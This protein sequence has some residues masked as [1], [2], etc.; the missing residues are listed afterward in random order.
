MARRLR[1][2]MVVLAACL[3]YALA[4]LAANGFD[5]RALV[6]IG[7]CYA[8]CAGVETCPAEVSAGYDGQFAYYIARDPLNAAPCLDVPAYRYQ[9]ILLP[10]LGRLLALGQEGALPLAFAAINLAAL[11]ISTAL[12]ERLLLERRVSRWYALVYGLF[13]GL[14]M[15]VR[16]ST[17]EPLAYGLAALALWLRL[18]GRAWPGLLALLLAAFAKETALTFAAAFILHDLLAR[19]WGAA[20][21]TA[22]VI[23]L[24]F[25]LWQAILYAGLGAFGVGSGGALGT[26]FEII[27]FN[28][29]WRLLYDPSSGPAVFLVLAAYIVPA[30]L[31]PSLW[32]LWQAGRDLRR[33]RADLLACCL[34]VNAALM[35]TVPFS[36][37][38]EPIGLFRFLPGL[39]LS[40]IL[41]AAE[42]WPRGRALRYSPLWLALL[43]Y[44]VAG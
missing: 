28:G 6:S 41:Y 16:L 2:W 18:R 3:A 26:P 43:V 34:L 37:Y 42:R 4:I 13:V 21:R 33:G 8:A 10:L 20:L 11:V 5:S 40:Y 7:A 1:P 12:V 19:R 39:V 17:T 44:L 14:V 25:A 32:G 38:R 15:G 36:T 35:A 24:P 22:L 27:P 23:G 29:F 30:A 9:R 31:L